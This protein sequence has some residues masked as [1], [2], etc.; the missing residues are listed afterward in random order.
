M[1]LTP[2][3]AIT[4]IRNLQDWLYFSGM[5]GG[6]K[7]QREALDIAVKALEKQIQSEESF[8]WCTDCKEYDQEKHCCHRFS[9]IINQTV[10]EV[11]G[12]TAIGEWVK[13]HGFVTPGGDPV[14]RCSNCGKGIH[15]F[16][17]EHHSYGADI[18]DNQWVA[19]PNC[20][21]IMIGERDG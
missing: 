13:V 16:G 14:W 1:E 21:T 17:V 18:A 3:E 15:V 5:N 8:E 6:T 11:R 12:T 2:K 20:G 4:E 9:K 19:C 7:I 10:E